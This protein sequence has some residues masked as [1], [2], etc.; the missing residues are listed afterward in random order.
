MPQRPSSGLCR[1]FGFTAQL[2]VPG[3]GNIIQ[4]AQ[5][6]SGSGMIML[7]SARRPGTD[8]AKLLTLPDEIGG[9]QTATVYVLVPDADAVYTRVREAGA[10]ILLDIK[11]EDYGGRGFTC[12]DLENHVWS[13]GTYDPYA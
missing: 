1:V 13:F 12:R 8:Y 2:V 7:G 5:L 9:L 6:L 4:H 3:E 11:D 10:A